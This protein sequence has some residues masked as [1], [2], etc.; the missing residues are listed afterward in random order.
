MLATDRK[1]NGIFLQHKQI[2]NQKIARQS[3]RVLLSKKGFA[4]SK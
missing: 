3:E 4:C 2:K 1:K